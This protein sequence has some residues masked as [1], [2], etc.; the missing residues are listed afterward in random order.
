MRIVSF[1]VGI[2]N[3][4][5][6]VLSF[7]EK[8]IMIHSN[9]PSNMYLNSYTI[10]YWD[11][12]DICNENKREKC[13][14]CKNFAK[15][16][17][18][19]EYYCKTHSKKYKVPT[20]ELLKT[21]K[22]K[23][24]ELIDF[25]NTNGIDFNGCKLKKEYLTLVDTYISQHYFEVIPPRNANNVSLVEL[26]KNMMMF[27]DKEFSKYIVDGKIQGIDKVIIENQI[28]TIA[29][30]MKTLQGMIAQ[31]FIMRDIQCVEFVSSANKLKKYTDYASKTYKERKK[32]SIEIMNKICEQNENV[33]QWETVFKNHKKKDDLADCY[34]QGIW[35]LENK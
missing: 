31:Y 34:L 1:D 17:K 22:L 7:D 33:K 26:G 25:C 29:S 20:K 23:L 24:T 5:L 16:T 9:K 30:R 6:C 19:N 10:D 12:L 2:K 4:A 27:L 32:S 18:N 13:Q 11:V 8:N 15:Y 14:S 28:S 3:L 35:Y 21:N